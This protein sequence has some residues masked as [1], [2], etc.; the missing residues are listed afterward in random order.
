[1]G[2]IRRIA[3]H[4]VPNPDAPAAAGIEGLHDAEF[5]IDRPVVADRRAGDHQIAR[6]RWRRRDGVLAAAREADVPGEVDRAV[7]AKIRAG[8]PVLPSSAISRPSSVPMKMRCA[9]GASGAAPASRQLLTPREVA[10]A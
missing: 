5:Q 1:M 8:R 6:D 3:R 4:R 10:S 9:Q 2:R 7:V